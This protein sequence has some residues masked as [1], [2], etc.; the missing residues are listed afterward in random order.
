MDGDNVKNKIIT[1]ILAVVIIIILVVGITFA[2]ITWRSNNINSAGNS[3]C[4]DILYVKG[5]DIGSDQNKATLMPSVD[6]TGGLSS[7]VKIGMNS[8]CTS[9]QGKGIIKLHTLPDTSSNLFREGLLNYVVLNGTTK[10]KEGSITSTD[11]IDIDIGDL[12]KASSV[13]NADSYTV[14]VWISNDLVEN[15]DAFSNYYGKITA[16]VE[17][18]D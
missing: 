8:K 9:V 5:T 3:E 6:Y 11:V 15:S 13:N 12:K 16:S 1:S 10:I 7:T 18:Y 4:F 2:Y 14:Y 17:Q